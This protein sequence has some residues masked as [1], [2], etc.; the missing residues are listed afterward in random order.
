MAVENE[1]SQATSR[2]ATL[3]VNGYP[4]ITAPTR[5]Q[6]LPED[7]TATFAVEAIGTPFFNDNPETPF[8]YTW[9]SPTG[10]FSSGTSHELVIPVAQSHNGQWHV[11]V[12][13]RDYSTNCYFFL[14]VQNVTDCVYSYNADFD[15]GVLI[16]LNH[17]VANQLQ[18]NDNPT[19]LPFINVP[20]SGTSAWPGGRGTFARINV[21]SGEIMGEYCTAPFRYDVLSGDRINPNPSRT[22]V[23]RF[24][25]C[26]VAN[27]DDEDIQGAWEG[28]ITKFGIVIGGIRCARYGASPPYT[29]IARGNGEF[30]RPPFVY[31]TCPDRDEDGAIRTSRGLRNVLDWTTPESPDDETILKYVRIDCPGTRTLAVDNN[32]NVWVG[33][34]HPNRPHMHQNIDG[35]TGEIMWTSNPALSTGG[36]AGVINDVSGER[37]PWSSYP[38]SLTGDPNHPVLLRLKLSS[39]E[40]YTLPASDYTLGDYGVAVDP[41]NHDVW[42]SKGQGSSVV[43][44]NN[45]GSNKATYA[46]NSPIGIHQ[47]L[48]VDNHDNVWIAHGKNGG[49]TVGHILTN[50]TNIGNVNLSSTHNNKPGPTGVSIDTNQKVWVANHDANN[51][52]RINPN[53]S[54]FSGTN[55][56]YRIGAVDLIV[57]LENENEYENENQ[58]LNGTAANPYAMSDMTGFVNLGATYPSGCW[59]FVQDGGVDYRNWRKVSWTYFTPTGTGVKV[60]VRAA[61]SVTGL[62]GSGDNLNSFRNATNNMDFDPAVTGRYLEVRVTLWRNPGTSNRP[63]LYDLTVHPND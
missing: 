16:N 32:N 61:N 39:K 40:Y 7:S 42:V 18:I 22:A 23:D 29:F 46:G 37:W 10:L 38:T 15:K 57:N 27:R 45:T 4:W 5:D 20:C 62:P 60:E 26:W 13:N 49:S 54:P 52:M 34:I 47:G 35:E 17:N 3:T 41:K 28:S 11:N 58:Y 63:L 56:Q 9:Y 12:Q 50:G 30:L 43:K 6:N 19:P 59:I 53:S 51:V 14:N 1:V 2:R 33:G 24:G 36:Y 55:N 8:Y 31:N 25:N 48:V 44:Y 21:N